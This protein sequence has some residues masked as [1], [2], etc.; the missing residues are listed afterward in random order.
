MTLEEYLNKSRV[1]KSEP[2]RL[3]KMEHK[4]KKHGIMILPMGSSIMDAIFYIY[5]DKSAQVIQGLVD[6]NTTL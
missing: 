3:L 2:D 6:G 5:G 4:N 1:V